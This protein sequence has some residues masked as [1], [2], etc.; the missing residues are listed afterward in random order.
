MITL[1]ISQARASLPDLL[2]RVERGEEITITRHGRAVAVLI[3]PDVLRAH[4][5][6]EDSVRVNEL[7]SAAADSG[8]SLQTGLTLERAEQLISAIR[9]DREHR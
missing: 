4:V 6:T 7:V 3:R 8:L 5:V 9:A 2:T 1:T